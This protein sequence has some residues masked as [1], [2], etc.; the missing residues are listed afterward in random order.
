MALLVESFKHPIYEI[1]L[2][3]PE[4]KNALNY[5]LTSSLLQALLRASDK[6]TK[7]TILRG[8]EG[9]FSAGGDVREFYESDDTASK[10]DH[11]A[12]TLNEVIRTIRCMPSIVIGVLE[13]LA[14]GAG[15]SVALACDLVVATED[16]TF[17]MAYRRIGLTPDGGGSIFLPRIVGDKRCNFL[18][19]LSRDFTAKEAETMG[20]INFVFKQEELEEKLAHIVEELLALPHEVIPY[21]KRL[22]NDALYF[23]LENHLEKERR[24][25]GELSATQ[26]FKQRVEAFLQRKRDA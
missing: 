8:S 25:V 16:S 19:L 3:R 11:V 10:V 24:F 18:Y 13:G 14:Y 26:T 6:G 21:Y 7:V 2:L 23:G 1:R 15:L 17:N 9:C 5:E 22:I 12:R 20:L 4:K